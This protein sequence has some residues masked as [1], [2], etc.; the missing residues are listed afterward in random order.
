[1]SMPD[2]LGKGLEALIPQD[3]YTDSSQKVEEIP[4]AKIKRNPYQPRTHFNTENLEALSESLKEHGL[5]QP[6]LVRRKADYFELIAGER[7]LRA[8]ELAGWTTIPAIIKDFTDL[9]SSQIAIIENI[10]REALS[11]MDTAVGYQRLIEDFN[12]THENIAQIFKR[13]RSAISNTLRLLKLPK[14]IQ[15][16]VQQDHISDGHA[17]VLLSLED[18]ES[19]LAVADRVIK[20]KLSVRALEDLI[21]SLAFGP[22]DSAR[23]SQVPEPSA[24]SKEKWKEIRK[25]LSHELQSDV[26]LQRSKKERGAGTIQ[27]P[28]K[29]EEELDRLFTVLSR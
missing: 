3:I 23:G 27:I 26:K 19:M 25:S 2:R 11:A 21:K 5:Q 15:K 8:S 18:E 6:I 22:L 9:E 20:E 29:S 14:A 17:K 28:F 4:I 16:L 12:F 1:M 13:S 7:R 10:E 24:D